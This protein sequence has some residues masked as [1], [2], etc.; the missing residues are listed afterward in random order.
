MQ[1]GLELPILFCLSLPNR[2]NHRPEPADSAWSHFYIAI[3][4]QGSSVFGW[5]VVLFDASVISCRPL[6]L[7]SGSCELNSFINIFLP[8]FKTG[9]C[10]LALTGF[11]LTILPQPLSCWDHRQAPLPGFREHILH[12]EQLCQHTSEEVKNSS[13]LLTA[14][15]LQGQVQDFH[16][17]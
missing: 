14:T 3:L 12:T 9:S 17:S 6:A 11:K 10:C 1:A 8:V 4:N 5:T 15:G 16:S 13:M 2:W 7:F